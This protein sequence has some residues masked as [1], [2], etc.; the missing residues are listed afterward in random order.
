LL[1]LFFDISLLIAIEGS[2]YD[3][4]QAALSWQVAL[5]SAFDSGLLIPIFGN[6]LL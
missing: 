3:V 4:S 2:S 1:R 6:I 5:Y